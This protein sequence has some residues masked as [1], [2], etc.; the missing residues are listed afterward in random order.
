MAYW[1]IPRTL[2]DDGNIRNTYLAPGGRMIMRRSHNSTETQ[3][4][5]TL[6]ENSEEASAVHRAPIDNQKQFWASRFRDAGWQTDRFIEGMMTTSNFYSQEVVQV[7]TDTWH[8]G[9]VVLVGDAAHCASPFSGMGASGSLVGAYVLAGEINGNSGDLSQ[10]L[11]RYDQT[12]RPFVK[13]IQNVRPALLRLGMPRAKVSI[14][15]FHA[16]GA[17]ACRLRLPELIARFSSDRD[18]SWT[19]PQYEQATLK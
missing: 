8:K 16:L 9:R 11:T 19:L 13:E 10:A 15:L 4:Y 1:F 6:R 18:G 5:F 3:V 14:A 17:L 12:L 7:C 2:A